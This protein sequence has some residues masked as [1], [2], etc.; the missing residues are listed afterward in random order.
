MKQLI[1][2]R[3]LPNSGKSTRAKEIYATDPKNTVMVNKDTLRLMVNGDM[4]P[5]EHETLIHHIQQSVVESIMQRGKEY[6]I[7]VDNTHLTDHSY[8]GL[9]VAAA[10]YGYQLEFIDFRHVPLE[11]CLERNAA[12]ERKVPESIIREMWE[13]HI[14]PLGLWNVPSA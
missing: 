14:K 2:M 10:T 7:I 9:L 6:T 3:G 11:V 12:R 13:K 5:S 4:T 8:H 1:I